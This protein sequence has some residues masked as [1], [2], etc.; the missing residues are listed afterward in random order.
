MEQQ[1]VAIQIDQPAERGKYRSPTN[2]YFYLYLSFICLPHLVFFNRANQ[3]TNG[4]LEGGFG[5]LGIYRSVIL[6]SEE[7]FKTG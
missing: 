4:A 7:F 6:E 2:G 3:E 5:R 1:T